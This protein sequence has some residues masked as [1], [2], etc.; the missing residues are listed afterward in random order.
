MPIRMTDDPYDPS[1]DDSGGGGG[2]RRG[3]GG[4]GGGLG[5]LLPLI[6]SLFGRGG[7]KGG[8]II[9]LLLGAAAYFFLGRGG[10]NSSTVTNIVRHFSESGYEFNKDTFNK[11][12]IYEELTPDDEKNP[13]PEA[14]SLLRFAP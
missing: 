7:G 4:G 13:L 9:I 6:L 5:A 1:Q 2:G 12:S 3:P 11:A 8:I 14:V 10:C